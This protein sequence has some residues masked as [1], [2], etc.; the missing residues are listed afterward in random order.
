[1]RLI[2]ALASGL[3][4][5]LGLMVSGM[6]NP[7]KVLGFLDI[8]GDWDPSLAF[9]M[10]AAIPVA[11]A[12]FAVARRFGR[13]A[14]AQAFHPPTKT[15]IDAPLVAGALLFGIGWGLAGF[16]PGPALASAA[17]GGWRAP[18]F[19]AATIVGMALFRF[20]GSRTAGRR[21]PAAL[22]NG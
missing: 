14:Y 18:V 22:S 19:V 10:G 3:L 2:S 17:L 8:T 1:M 7:A 21:E 4:F 13:P 11:A 16:C 9:V 15:R 6:I 5:G 20:V 12:G